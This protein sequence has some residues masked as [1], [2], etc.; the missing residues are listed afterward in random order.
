MA[1][2]ENPDLNSLLREWT[3]TPLPSPYT[4]DKVL[5]HLR[6]DTSSTNSENSIFLL[7]WLQPRVALL[8]L[9]LG[10]LAGVSYAEW[11]TLRHEDLQNSSL[12]QQYLRSIDP[13]YGETSSK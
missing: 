3:E 11:V 8:C 12:S 7:R 5:R 13:V 2:K 6:S 1:H 4:A 10:T 9:L